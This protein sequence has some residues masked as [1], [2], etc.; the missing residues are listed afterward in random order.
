MA[1]RDPRRSH[2]AKRTMGDQDARHVRSVLKVRE[3]FPVLVSGVVA[4]MALEASRK[5]AGGRSQR[6]SSTPA[7][8]RRGVCSPPVLAGT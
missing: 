4:R 8:P 5:P 1:K 7:K 6:G 3:G 2:Q